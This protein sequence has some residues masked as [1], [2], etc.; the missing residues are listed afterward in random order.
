MDL[1]KRELASVQDAWAM[2][3]DPIQGSTLTC[4]GLC[5]VD[6]IA[7]RDLAFAA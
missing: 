1:Q 4:F 3:Q 5:L 6:V 7:I 2:F